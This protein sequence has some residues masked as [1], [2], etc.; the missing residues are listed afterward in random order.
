MSIIVDSGIDIFCV[1]ETWLKPYVSSKSVAIAGYTFIRNDRP[2]VRG[3][4]VGIYV[5]KKLNYKTVFRSL[6]FGVCESLFLEI[7]SGSSKTLVGVV[8][9]PHGNLEV[10]EDIHSDILATYSDIIIVGDFNC[11]LFNIAK[12]SAMRSA[13]LSLGLTIVHNSLPTHFDISHNS[14]SLI[15]YTLLSEP[16]K[17]RLSSQVQCDSISHHALIFGAYD[18]QVSY[19]DKFVEFRDYNNIDWVGFHNFLV[20]FDYEPIYTSLD[21]DLQLST[22]D[23]LVSSLFSFVPLVKRRIIQKMDPWLYSKNVLLSRS[24]RDIAHKMY[25]ANPTTDNWRIF[26]A[27]R[28]KAKLVMRRMKRNY[29]VSGF[30]N[31]DNSQV[32]KTLRE[33]GCFGET[34]VPDVDVNAANSYFLCDRLSDTDD[35]VNLHNLLSTSDVNDSFSFDCIFEYDI[36]KAMKCIK[37]NSIGVDGIPIRFIKIIF[38]FV[39]RHILH[40]FNSILTASVF[41]TGWK[42]ARVVPVPKVSGSCVVDNFRPISILPALSKMFEYIMND[43][44]M[45]FVNDRN[46]ISNHQYGFRHGFNTTSHLIHLTDTIRETINKGSCGVLVGLDL[47]KAFD[48]VDHFKLISKL[49]EDFRFSKTACKLLFSYVS[50]RSQFVSLNSVHSDIQSINCGVPQGSILGPLLFILYIND[51]VNHID[52]SCC[53]FL[54]ADDIHLFFVGVSF[55]SLV[56]PI[57]S[58]LENI[59]VWLDRNYLCINSSKTKAMCFGTTSGALSDLGIYMNDVRVDIVHELKVLGIILDSKLDFSSHVNLLVS[60][61]FFVLRRLYSTN[62]YLPCYIRKRIAFALLMSH[63]NYGIELTSGTTSSRFKRVERLFN[64]VVRYV[65]RL[66]RYDH[67]SQYVLLFLGFPFESHVNIRVLLLYYK[68]INSGVPP[69]LRDKFVFCRSTRNPQLLIP[70]ITSQFYE[71][72][73]LVRVARLWNRLPMHLRNFSYSHHVFQQKFIDH[74]IL[75]V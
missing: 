25:I 61:V 44:M 19:C 48:R 36:F 34:S 51:I 39:S 8:Y 43:S 37:S 29:S 49:R 11:N 15:D 5:S 56:V 9:L 59:K 73:F 50:G 10:F 67:I 1:S 31:M 60:K 20:S 68:L 32:F 21:V 40:L 22:I 71:R 74:T 75:N 42:V 14:S 17:V 65:Y 66:R 53:P 64:S 58:T 38:P 18:S 28:N 69:L 23:S 41:P 7:N 33:S 27:Y 62:V 24:L 35:E 13:C 6:D 30:R 52:V 46:M 47:S 2:A 26:C 16:A 70:R 72:S 57:N 54:Y 4:G 12:A 63:I 55:S 45:S 3:G